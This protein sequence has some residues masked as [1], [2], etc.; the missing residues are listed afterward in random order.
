MLRNGESCNF[1]PASDRAIHYGDGAFETLRIRQRKPLLLAQHLERLRLTCQ[2]LRIPLDFHLLHSEISALLSTCPEDG[3]LKILV[4]RGSGG[5]GYRPPD[6]PKPSRLLQ[7]HP[8][9]TSYALAS[10]QG[11]AVM[12]CAHPISRNSALAGMKHLNRLDQV[13]A[14][15]ELTA[16]FD[17]GFMC[18]DQGKLIEGT[19][20][21]IFIFKNGTLLTPSLTDSGVAGIMRAQVI[22]YFKQQHSIPLTI[23]DIRPHELRNASEVFITN[24]VF[25]ISP[26]TR[27]R[28]EEDDLQFDTGPVTQNIKSTLW[29]PL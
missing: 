19:R 22:D 27:I 26:V 29:D 9:P 2:F 5:R 3:V 17:E 8:L 7:I 1:L 6:K 28:I 23:R 24:S 15:M 13:L 12:C 25:G 11:I 16:E 4:S 21:N 14:S 18:D 10:N 20:T